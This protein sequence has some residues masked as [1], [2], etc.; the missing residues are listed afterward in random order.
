MI[1]NLFIVDSRVADYQALI[2]GLSAD[3]AWVL[4]DSNK[5]GL[6]QMQTALAGYSG[7]DSIQVISHG[8]AGTLYLGSTVLDQGNLSSYTDQLRAIGDALNATGDIL[9]YGCDVA[10]GVSGQDFI[11]QLASL[12]GAEVAASTG[13]TGA[14]E[15]GGD[16]ELEAA[17]GAI[18]TAGMNV[19]DYQGLLTTSY[20]ESVTITGGHALVNGLGGDAGFGENVLPANDD[21]S[22][23]LIDISSVFENGILFNGIVYTGLYLNNNGNITFATPQSQFTPSVISDETSNPLLAVYFADVDTQGGATTPTPGGN[24]TGSNLVYWDLDPIDNVIT[25]TW[26]DV[27][28][29][30]QNTDKLNAFQIRLYDTGNSNM[31]IEYRYEDIN[32]TTGDLSGGTDGLG[33]VVAR[34]GWTSGDGMNYEE[35]AV[36][37][38]QNGMLNLENLSNIDQ[39]GVFV[40]NVNGGVVDTSTIN[41]NIAATDAILYEGNSGLTP[42]TFTVIRSGDTSQETTVGWSVNGSGDKPADNADFENGSLPSGTITFA[43][44]ETEQTITVNVQGD[45]V[46]ETDESFTVTLEAAADV[47][48]QTNTA[49]GVILNDETAASRIW[50]TATDAVKYEGD[51]GPTAFTFTVM[52]DG[53]ISGP[54]SVDWSVTGSGSNPAYNIDFVGGVLPS[55]TVTFAAGESSQIITVNVQGDTAFE[56]DESFTVSLANPVNGSLGGSPSPDGNPATAT[57]FIAINTLEPSTATDIA[58]KLLSAT[59]GL[60]VLSAQ[61]TGAINAVS[62]FDGVNLG[63]AGGGT[64]SLGAGVLLTTGDGTPPLSNTS[65]SYGQDNGTAGDANLDAYALAAFSYAGSTYDAAI[66]NITF[67]VA[68]L[69]DGS[70]PAHVS[71]DIMFGSDEYPE[72]S[73]TSYVDIAAIEVDG[74]NYAYFNQNIQQPLSVIS[75]NLSAGNFVDNQGNILAIEY[76]GISAPLRVVGSLNPDLSEHTIRIA[77]ADTGDYAYDSGIFVSNLRVAEAGVIDNGITIISQATADGMIQNDDA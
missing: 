52:R 43:A 53:D 45:T 17:T 70:L 6:L 63:S 2:A 60:S 8:S 64:L 72:Y 30:D 44:G 51:S 37:G 39:P 18:E 15:Q 1:K 19:T 58:S 3:S 33:G 16:W 32:W 4:L 7:L 73:N 77:I 12:T 75:N 62:L 42:F 36:S 49:D 10:E 76:D 28:Y 11:A 9:L 66:I 50:V 67:S 29:Y 46:F 5:D 48:L 74:V 69:E 27:G 24:S 68:A 34:A 56:A 59:P 57:D 35:L 26:D 71:V 65:V 61:Y 14:S 40:F 55:G 54:A 25:F 23:D 20:L 41:V 31:V 38:N 13:P 21:S 22:T 47:T